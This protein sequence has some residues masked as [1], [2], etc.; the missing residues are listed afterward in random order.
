ML[1]W[2]S[3]G[4]RP[5]FSSLCPQGSHFTSARASRSQPTS[6]LPSALPPAGEWTEPLFPTPQC[7]G[8]VICGLSPPARDGDRSSPCRPRR[9]PASSQPLHTAR[10]PPPPRCIVGHAPRLGANRRRGALWDTPAPAPAGPSWRGRRTGCDALRA[11]A[12]P[13]AAGSCVLCPRRAAAALG[14]KTGLVASPRSAA[15]PPERARLLRWS[16]REARKEGLLFSGAAHAQGGGVRARRKTRSPLGSLPARAVLR[17]G[18]K[19]LR[20]VGP[21]GEPPSP[22]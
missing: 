22:F 16:G 6:I 11:A 7:D 10:L 18:V 13:T 20:A 9:H 1:A 15:A 8:A 3:T 17:P 2:L 14:G 4:H 21:R 19:S 5:R 12:A